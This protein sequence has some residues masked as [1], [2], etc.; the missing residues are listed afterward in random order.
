MWERHGI[1]CIHRSDFDVTLVGLT[2][3]KGT[4][5]NIFQIENN[6]FTRVAT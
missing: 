1:G 2:T 6:E 3:V 4:S 5:V